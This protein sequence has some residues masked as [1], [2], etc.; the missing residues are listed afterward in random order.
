MKI[1]KLDIF[2]GDGIGD[3]GEVK[4]KKVKAEGIKIGAYFAYVERAF[5]SN[6][7]THIKTGYS[8]GEV[9]GYDVALA[10]ASDVEKLNQDWDF[11]DIYTIKGWD[12]DVRKELGFLRGAYEPD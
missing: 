11:T 6:T 10:Y 8:V 7:L 1:I 5:S 2:V 9:E 4:A 3:D 12:V